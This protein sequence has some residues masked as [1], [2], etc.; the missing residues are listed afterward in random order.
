MDDRGNIEES[1]G[2]R[3]PVSSHTIQEPEGATSSTP[4]RIRQED[5]DDDDV[6]LLQA[7][8]EEDDA[9]FLEAVNEVERSVEE[10]DI[11]DDLLIQAVTECEAHIDSDTI[12]Q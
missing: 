7:L 10:K 12:I 8:D 9:S 3:L 6:S 5:D 2:R 4:M 1:T 11:P